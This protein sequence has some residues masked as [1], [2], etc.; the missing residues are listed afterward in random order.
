MLFLLG[1]KL[2]PVIRVLLG[3]ALIAV[4][5]AMTMHVLS[6][7]GAFVLAWGGYTWFRRWRTA[8]RGAGPGKSGAAR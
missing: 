5:I 1:V 3:A 8:G 4:G 7:L 2:H 6:V